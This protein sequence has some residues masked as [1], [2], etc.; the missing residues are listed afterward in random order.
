MRGSYEQNMDKG[1][2]RLLREIFFLFFFG[3]GPVEI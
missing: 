3:G 2:G 1:I